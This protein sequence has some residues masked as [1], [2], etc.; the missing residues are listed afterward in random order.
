VPRRR[1]GASATPCEVVSTRRIRLAF[2]G[3]VLLV[4]V[5]AAQ[6]V[7][8][9]VVEAAVHAERGERQRIRTVELTATRGRIYDREGAVL[10][11]SVDSATIHAD[12]AAFRSALGSDGRTL[13]AVGDR[14]EVA[15]ALAPLLGLE[16]A[17]LVERLGRDGR[18]VYL[19]RQID[20]EVG[21]RV[22]ALRL[23]GIGMI[24][25][26]R[27]AYPSAGLA[28]QV[29]GFTGIDGAGLEGLEATHDRVLRGRP[30]TM[31]LERAPGGLAI[32]SGARELVPA[33]PGAD[34]VLTIDRE[35]QHVAERVA[36]ETVERHGA[37]G[38]TVVVLEVGTG[39]VL[40]MASA[41]S[42]DPSVP[43][44]GDPA[45]WRNRAVTDL[46]EPGS[47]QKAL[48][49]AV[50][51]E[52]GAITPATTFQVA[53]RYRV[54]GHTFSDVSRHGT[55]TWTV[56]DIMARSSNVGTI[57]VAE[58][59][60]A[61]ALRT[62]LLGLGQGRPTGLGFPGE[63]A[64]R[65]PG[66]GQWWATTLPTVAIGYGTSTTLLQL[67]T[68]YATIANGGIRVE[69]R[70]VRGTVGADGHL[71]P[72]PAS[73]SERVLSQRTAAIVLEMLAGAVE[74]EA[75]T[76][77]R[78]AVPGYRVGG[79][80]GTA[81]KTLTGSAGYSDEYVASFVGVAPLDDPRLVVAVMV[82]APRPVYFGGLVAAPAF[83]E[84]MHASLLARRIVPDGTGMS[85]SELVR[86]A[87][88]A[89]TGATEADAA[90]VGTAP[91]R[92]PGR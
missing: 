63:V 92:T 65:V 27:R 14:R 26:P 80:T 15:R 73:T 39:D 88:D 45:L 59:L 46:F 25:E 87:N 36:L 32:S 84:V 41:P 78:A 35:I 4:G 82:D 2:A 8:V 56:G 66:P 57:L 24:V 22:M 1:R 23:P 30:G 7:R 51:L 33:L 71:E 69:P 16:E 20:L 50:A 38:A 61:E 13:P 28:A 34:L 42:F 83:S 68:S 74:G 47:T 79:K 67:A 12:P 90:D 37:R 85:L 29:I 17:D 48:T 21:E 55:S 10:A 86:S 76:G 5:A 81:R 54:G 89:A 40:G 18:F 43:R 91:S 52:A 31:L 64:G 9:Q 62:G 44:T 58:R 75:A 49:V 19:A 3:A 72:A 77:S 70:L 11:T 60:G 6:L 53:D